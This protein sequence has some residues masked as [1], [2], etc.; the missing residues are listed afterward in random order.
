[1]DV[2]PAVDVLERSVVRLLKGD[3]DEVTVYGENVVS[4][5][6]AWNDRGASLVHVVDLEGART[7][8]P[9]V[10]LWG[11]L[12]AAGVG[13]QVGGGIRDVATAEAAIAAG[14]ARVVMGTAA[15]WD[16]DVLRAVVGAVG[17]D[18]VVVALDVRDGRATGAGW[19]D[20]GR[21]LD[22][23]VTD[24]AAAGVRRVLV[25]GIATDGTMAGP[26]LG[27]V[28]DVLRTAPHL[29]VIGSGGVGTLDDLRHFAAAGVEA[30]IVGRALYEERFTIEDAL[31][32]D[33]PR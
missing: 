11:E 20:E 7:G 4:T 16:A 17:A 30:A 5:A 33:A 18:R 14:A 21:P 6:H 13:F 31:G 27:V 23:V 8:S 3:Y 26:D 10:S 32:L 19:L 12:G 22:A 29:A 25:T 24:I 1:M 2:I 15:V 28:A 9:D